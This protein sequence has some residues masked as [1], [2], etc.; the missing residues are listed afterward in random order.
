M[1]SYATD[2]TSMTQGR[3][4]YSMEFSH[5]DYVPGELADKVIAAHKPAHG[6]ALVEEEA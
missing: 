1:L 6:E 5:Y 2:L 4:S 3:A